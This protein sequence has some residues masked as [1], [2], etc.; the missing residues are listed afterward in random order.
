MTS[1]SVSPGSSRRSDPTA[2]FLRLPPEDSPT[3][4]TRA[5]DRRNTLRWRFFCSLVVQNRDQLGPRS[6]NESDHLM[7]PR[8]LA[9]RLVENA[10][11]IE[12]PLAEVECALELV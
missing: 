2:A 11:L 12:R 1:I 3:V 4:E 6:L 9:Y 8:L 5:I 7:H 10:Q